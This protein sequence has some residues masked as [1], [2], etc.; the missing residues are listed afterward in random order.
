MKIKPEI[1]EILAASTTDGNV[2]Y[3]PK[4][5]LERSVYEAVNK[6]LESI[7]GKWNKKAKGH[8]FDY[9]PSEALDNLLLS[10]ETTDA[11]KIYQFFP[12]PRPVAERM[13]DMAELSGRSDVLEPSCGK[14]DIMDVIHE[15]GVMYLYGVELNADMDKYLKSKPYTTTTGVDFLEF[16]EEVKEGKILN[17]WTHIIMNPPFSKQQD[18]AHIMAAYSILK[19]GG[20]LVSIASPSP[21]FRTDKKSIAFREWLEA[22]DAEVEEVP[23]GSFKESGTL[24]RTM[25][26]KVIKS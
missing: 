23:E 25:L 8:I 14:G 21:W 10:G 2:L 18:I 7:G 17:M 11:K 24:I 15:R 4:F 1:S 22:V 6:C 13:C 26:I 9:D 20:V 5:Q 3:L 19:P 16:A 12:T